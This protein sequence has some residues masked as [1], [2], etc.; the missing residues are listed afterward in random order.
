MTTTSAI[1]SVCAALVP[2]LAALG[3]AIRYLVRIL[4]SIERV[5]TMAEEVAK[6]LAAHIESSTAAHTALSDKIASHDR[7]L[8]V[9]NTKLASPAAVP[10]PPPAAGPTAA[11]Q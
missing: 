4:A 3:G 8:A 5:T 11:A 9:V 7:D 6:S 2:V 1:V 10:V